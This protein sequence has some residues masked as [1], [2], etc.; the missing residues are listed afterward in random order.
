M[1]NITIKHN[2]LTA[3]GFCGLWSSVWGDPP[4]LEQVELAL[5]NTLFS[6][7]AY[8]G[9][10]LIVM[11]RM[12]GDKGL[13]CYIKDV[14]VS[15]GYQS[16]GIGRALINELLGYVEE[17]GISGTDVFVELAAVPDKIPFY[18]KLGFDENDAHRLKKM[19]HIK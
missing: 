9:E 8:D 16:R 18:E 10:K 12:I 19:H 14:I 17:N 3:E 13:C 1:E 5:A 15:P 7:S 11:A 4:K 6:V 2:V